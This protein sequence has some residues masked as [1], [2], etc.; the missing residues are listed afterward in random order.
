MQ[1]AIALA[2]LLLLQTAD[3][4]TYKL[5]YR[6][7][8][9]DEYT[10][11]TTRLIKLEI[12]RGKSLAVFDIRSKE[13]LVRKVEDADKGKP[14]IE[15]VV[16]KEFTRETKKHPEQ[17]QLGEE[18]SGA[19]GRTFVW[20]RVNDERWGLFGRRAEETARFKP[21]VERLKNWRDS[22]LPKT[23]VKVGETWKIPIKDF[24]STTGQTIPK[25]AEGNIEFKLEG[26]DDKG[27]GKITFGGVWTYSDPGARV[28]VTQKG[29]WL[30][31]IK[32]GR[33]LE[34]KATGKIDMTGD[35][36]GKGTLKMERMVKWKEKK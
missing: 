7:R 32:R 12:I 27:V 14:L 3:T 20:R 17:D 6:F 24:L 22:R 18:T 5:E 26:V 15:N 30:F 34:I 21:V 9:G 13:V 10:D 36:E 19:I 28:I 11:S 8:K 2:C 23:A 29:S 4:K 1:A 25:G 33:D 35:Q 16:V 31:D